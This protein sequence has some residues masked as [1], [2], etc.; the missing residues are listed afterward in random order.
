MGVVS[1]GNT[2]VHAM[3]RQ[4]FGWCCC[5]FGGP[6]TNR[7]IGLFAP[8]LN[9]ER[10]S[11]LIRSA[12][13]S[14]TREAVKNFFIVACTKMQQTFVGNFPAV[15]LPPWWAEAVIWRFLAMFGFTASAKIVTAI[16]RKTAYRPNIT[17]VWYYRRKITAILWF[18][19]LR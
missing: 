18:Y 19:H 3:E 14:Y 10:I 5:S 2:V 9:N 7:T 17:A 4:K 15:H 8:S 6:S 12:W 13:L 1:A 11:V 16:K